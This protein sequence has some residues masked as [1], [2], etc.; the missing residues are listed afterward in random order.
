MTTP[1]PPSPGRV[2]HY[3][4]DAGPSRG[5]VRPAHVIA[6]V[7]ATAGVVDLHVHVLTRDLEPPAA[8]RWVCLAEERAVPYGESAGEWHWP[9]R[10]S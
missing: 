5:Q 2:V 3:V 4:L 8:S 10:V 9:P 1:H 7:D 6:V